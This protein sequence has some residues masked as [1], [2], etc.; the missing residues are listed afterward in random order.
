MAKP[1]V[2]AIRPTTNPIFTKMMISYMNDEMSF[3]A[4]NAA[5]VVPVNEESGT[6][7]TF[8]SKYWFKDQLERRAYGDTFAR[9]GYDLGSDTYKT[10]HW[11]L[12][13]P[14]PVEHQATSQTPASLTT[15]G[16]EWL[17]TQS[18]MRKEEAFA[19]D[20]MTTSV[21]TTDDTTAQDWDTTGNPI[22]D[23]RTAKR[24]IRQA[25]G[26]PGNAA[27]MGEIV[28]DALH[29]NAEI[30]GMV[31]Y[32]ESLT[33]DRRD[34]LMAS[35]LGLDYLLVGRAVRNTA[36]LGQSASLSPFI[37]DDCLVC[38]IKPGA[39]MMTV[40]SMKTFTWAPGGGQ[41]E[42]S[43]YNE[44]Q[45]RNSTIL[46]HVEQWDQKLITADGGYFFSDIV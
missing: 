23:V 39:D 29:T 35:V 42:I 38:I 9:A 41:G 1:T 32:T 15:L 18:L 11:G 6:Y 28:Y 10:L 25:L 26:V 7:F 40:S 21:W 14:I 45:S 37:D 4:T 43:T 34:A 2:A 3:V 24:T 27:V 13:H 44:P 33:E 19:T 46:Q 17:G 12:E 22:N 30:L 5:P 20:F 31:Q 16:I 36:N 8:S